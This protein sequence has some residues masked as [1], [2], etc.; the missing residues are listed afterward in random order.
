MVVF[1]FILQFV[2]GCWEHWDWGWGFA[3]AQGRQSSFKSEESQ[4]LGQKSPN[5]GGNF[6]TVG[7]PLGFCS[8]RS[9]SP[10]APQG[11]GSKE[12]SCGA[13]EKRAFLSS[14]GVIAMFS[15]V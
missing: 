8:F 4:F 11:F 5:S 15:L 2:V 9:C 7:R 1:C 12:I 13:S 10:E 3:G 6:G 14:Q